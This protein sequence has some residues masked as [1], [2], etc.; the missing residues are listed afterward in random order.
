MEL[1]IPQE[2]MEYLDLNYDNSQLCKMENK[3]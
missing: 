2:K 3:V 1:E